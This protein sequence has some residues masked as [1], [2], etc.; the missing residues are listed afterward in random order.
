MVFFITQNLDKSKI[1]KKNI[2]IIGGS[3]LVGNKIAQILAYRNKDFI[4]FIGSRKSSS[5]APNQ[6]Q[7]DVNDL[8]SFDIIKKQGIDLIVLCTNDKLNN[9]LN[10]C[11]ENKVDYLDITKPTPDLENSYQLA[12]SKLLNS[13]IIFGSGWM[14]G[15]V[16][17]LAFFAKPKTENIETIKLFVYYSINDLA[18]ESSAHFM[19]EN[20]AKPFKVY[21]QNK[22]VLVKHFMNIENHDFNFD[23]GK[24]KCYNFDTP[25]LFILNQIEKIPTVE[26]KTTYSS[27]ATTLFLHY[28]Q[29]IKL[30]QILP[31]SVRKLLFSANGKGDKTVFEIVIKTS[32]ITKT[33]SLQS[34]LGQ[35][36]LT[37]FSTVL[38]IEKTIQTQ[39]NGLYFS[40]Q[41]FEPNE[42]YN[43]INSSKTINIKQ[44]IQ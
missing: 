33:I 37:A 18:G 26:V 44:D 6:I 8:K 28:F 7:I 27:K 4:L 17:S 38:N 5:E 42:F 13:K 31:L 43:L 14:G 40:H 10:F 2:L 12:K 21:R 39:K 29:F 36:Y 32:N 11:I 15:L 34:V 24:R 20:V 35:A 30:Y 41:L 1:M 9:I 23:I 3:G 25:D 22:S 19:A 16:S